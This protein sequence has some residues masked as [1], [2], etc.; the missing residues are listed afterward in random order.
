MSNHVLDSM[1]DA[2]CKMVFVATG[3]VYAF[4]YRPSGVSE[5]SDTT[6]I[7]IASAGV[8]IASLLSITKRALP[9]LCTIVCVLV[10]TLAVV[11][12]AIVFGIF[13]LGGEDRSREV[14][15]RIFFVADAILGNITCAPCTNA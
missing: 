7:A 6:W 8:A 3:I 9:M 13:L 15:R 1:L 5:L 11:Y 12:G 10:C 14:T 2:A 4:Q